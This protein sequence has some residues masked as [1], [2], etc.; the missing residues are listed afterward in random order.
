[1]DNINNVLDAERKLL[2]DTLEKKWKDFYE[3]LKDNAQDGIEMRKT[4]IREYE[5]EMDRVM[6]EHHEEYRSQKITLALENQE[7]QQK[8]QDMKA[9]CMLNVEK[10]NYSYA[11]LKHKD[12]EN[13]IIKNEQKRRINKSVYST[14]R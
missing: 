2:L 12:E 3:K 4:I 1:M 10:L 6:T 14:E 13:T 8:L 7:L 5:E 9:L 11:V